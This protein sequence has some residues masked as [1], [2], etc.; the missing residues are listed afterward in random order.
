[1]AFYSPMTQ[2]AQLELAVESLP[3]VEL[4]A[5]FAFIS[6]RMKQVKG[7]D[8][9]QLETTRFRKPNLHAGAW[10]VAEDF[11]APLP[12]EFWLGNDS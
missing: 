10:I 1:M 2:L 3:P 5:L 11:D 9:G 7:L 8:H 12:D 6:D 4:K